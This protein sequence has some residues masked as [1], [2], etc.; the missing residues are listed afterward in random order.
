MRLSVLV[1]VFLLGLLAAGRAGDALTELREVRD[2]LM[3]RTVEISWLKPEVEARFLESHRQAREKPGTPLYG[4][5]IS[6]FVEPA[7]PLMVTR[8]SEW[9]GHWL[10]IEQILSDPARYQQTLR[11]QR[12]VAG[13][14]PLQLPLSPLEQLELHHDFLEMVELLGE[15]LKVDERLGRGAAPPRFLEKR[16]ILAAFLA[17][18]DRFALNDN[19]MK[20]LPAFDIQTFA[21]GKVDPSFRHAFFVDTGPLRHDL[22]AHCRTSG[23]I[24][25]LVPD[26]ASSIL[27]WLAG[28][29]PTPKKGDRGTLVLAERMLAYSSEG[30]PSFRFPKTIR[31]EDIEGTGSFVFSSSYSTYRLDGAHSPAPVFRKLADDSGGVPLAELPNVHNPWR[32]KLSISCIHCHHSS[33]H[34]R[35]EVVRPIRPVATVPDDTA[36]LARRR[37]DPILSY[38]R[39]IIALEHAVPSNIGSQQ[40]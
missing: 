10:S 40:Q 38:A 20:Q 31:L 36:I 27:D 34:L 3:R 4:F 5:E 15:R 11:V 21:Q 22:E 24:Y 26:P 18:M 35:S 14:E 37:K 6:D 9:P 7:V 12:L 30:H 28:R 19:Q 29:I 17:F 25:A 32:T 13:L 2:A 1:I 8:W 23:L 16:A 33:P 39:K